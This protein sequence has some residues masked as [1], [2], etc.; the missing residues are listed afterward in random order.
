MLIAELSGW[1]AA[2]RVCRDRRI[3]H[4]RS[5]RAATGL[6]ARGRNVRRRPLVEGRGR[7]AQ[8]HKGCYCGKA[9]ARSII[10]DHWDLRNEDPV[11]GLARRVEGAM[12][13]QSL[14]TGSRLAISGTHRLGR[15][16]K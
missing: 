10:T 11:A 7:R 16:M 12:G 8:T 9:F 3:K 2:L 14:V 5:L 15:E 6:V 13:G 4:A 1:R